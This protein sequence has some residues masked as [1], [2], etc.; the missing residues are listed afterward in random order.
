MVTY[1]YLYLWLIFLKGNSLDFVYFEDAFWHM[2][3]FSI[4]LKFRIP[5]FIT[6]PASLTQIFPFSVYKQVVKVQKSLP[7]FCYVTKS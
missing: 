5:M 7:G 1:T 6:S 3:Q 4:V 2:T